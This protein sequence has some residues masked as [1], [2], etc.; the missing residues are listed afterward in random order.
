M[1]R[2]SEPQASS[3]GEL[4]KYRLDFAVPFARCALAMALAG[5]RQWSAAEQA[6]SEATH[7]CPGS[8]RRPRRTPQSLSPGTAFCSAR[9]PGVCVWSCAG[10]LARGFA[11]VSS[12]SNVLKSPRSCVR[13]KGRRCPRDSRRGT[14]DHC[15][16]RARGLDTGRGGDL[17]TPRWFVRRVRASCRPGEGCVRDWSVRPARHGLPRRVPSFS[18]SSC[19]RR[20][21]ASSVSS[22]NASEIAISQARPAIRSRL[23]T[24]VD[25]CS[26]QG[27]AKSLS[28]FGMASQTAR[29]RSFC[30][31]SSRR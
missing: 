1:R 14:R 30:T 25:C 27:S 19:A 29:S 6:A 16:D 26:L 9:S 2:R 23:R 15:G 13:R 4:E 5:R 12:R 3:V 17:R 18:P 8:W 22:L 31:S 21:T 20:A 24:T 7:A 11:S 10:P 28:S